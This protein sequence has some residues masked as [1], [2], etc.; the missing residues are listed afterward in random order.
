MKS[1]L[2]FIWAI[3]LSVLGLS[4]ERPSGDQVKQV[5]QYYYQGG[6]DVAPVLVDY[7]VCE[8]VY[9]EGDE[10]NNCENEL[11]INNISV[12]EPFYFWANFMVPSENGN[13]LLMHVNTK[14]LTRAMFDIKLSQSIRYR[15]FNRLTFNKVGAW[16]IKIYME[17]QDDVVE[18]ESIAVNVVEAL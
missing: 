17:T 14:G 12:D 18:L 4:T 9:R 2:V 1:I 7:K 6:E 8:N 10:K 15:N 13:N 5:L 16:E 3:S 11:D